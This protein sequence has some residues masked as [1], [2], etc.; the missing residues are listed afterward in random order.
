MGSGVVGGRDPPPPLGGGSRRGI[1]L[2]RFN[3]D[4]SSGTMQSQWAW[5]L[6]LSTKG[7]FR[8]QGQELGGMRGWARVRVGWLAS[9]SAGTLLTQRNLLTFRK[10]PSQSDKSPLTNPCRSV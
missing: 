4:L 9:A 10:C 3:L 8:G 2:A 5:A 7:T 6:A 1:E